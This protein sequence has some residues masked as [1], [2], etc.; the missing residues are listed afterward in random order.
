MTL[1][2]TL[3]ITAGQT[4]TVMLSTRGNDFSATTREGFHLYQAGQRNLL[5]ETGGTQ[6]YE[7]TK[8]LFD[9][10]PTEWYNFWAWSINMFNN[11]TAVDPELGMSIYKV[12]FTPPGIVPASNSLN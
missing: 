9:I 10:Y 7:Y 5:I 8:I 12:F 2:K 11:N 4:H 1:P 3:G 6:P